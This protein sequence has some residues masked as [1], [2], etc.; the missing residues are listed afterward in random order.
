MIKSQ[1]VNDAKQDQFM[2]KNH[3]LENLLPAK[4]VLQ[5]FVLRSAF[6]DGHN[7]GQPD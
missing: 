2:T 5:E 4:G 7:W 3:S 6:Q 1:R